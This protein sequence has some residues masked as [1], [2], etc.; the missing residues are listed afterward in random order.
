MGGVPDY[1][2]LA[3]LLMWATLPTPACV[4]TISGAACAF[5]V[6]L[7]L[8]LR[9]LRL[10]GLGATLDFPTPACVDGAFSVGGVVFAIL[11]V[12]VFMMW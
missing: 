3:V 6:D 1:I 5:Y 8:R 9:H 7:Q 11:L 12:V 10:L 2:F 4:A